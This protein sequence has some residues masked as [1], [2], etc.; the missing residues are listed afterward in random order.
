MKKYFLTIIVS[1]LLLSGAGFIANAQTL[2]EKK[3]PIPFPVS[4]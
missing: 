4:N 1:L 3:L 2:T